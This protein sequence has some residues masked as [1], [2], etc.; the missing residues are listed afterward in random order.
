MH[1]VE[2]IGSGIPRMH[3]I[4]KEE[5][6]SAPEFL[7]RGMFIVTFYRPVDFESWI[8]KWKGELSENQVVILRAIH[9]NHK[10]T[11][12]QLSKSI[13]IGTTTINNNIRKLK[14]IGLL[15]RIGTDKSGY[16]SIAFRADRSRKKK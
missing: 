1:M 2:Q 4:M 8:Q 3:E 12:P 10:I 11:H 7:T 9:V 5:G 15:E 13:G 16:W 6:L 14:K